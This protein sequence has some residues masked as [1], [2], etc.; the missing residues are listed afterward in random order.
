MATE[1]PR[2]QAYLEPMTYDLLLGWK[3]QRGIT[4]ESEAINQILTEYFGVSSSSAPVA[5]QLPQ[6]AIEKIVRNEVNALF[7]N[8]MEEDAEFWVNRLSERLATVEQSLERFVSCSHRQIDEL[9]AGLGERLAACEDSLEILLS[10]SPSELPSAENDTRSPEQLPKDE[11]PGLNEEESPT[12]ELESNPKESVVEDSAI[13]IESPG[14]PLGNSP[15]LS[16]ADLA[17]LLSPHNQTELAQRLG[18]NKS[19]VSRQK[20]KPD[21]EQWSQGKDPD[22]IGW[23]YDRS[24][25]MF[26]PALASLINESQ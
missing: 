25:Q 9:K 13:S 2:I 5:Q 20:G 6:E 10:D 11:A 24:S 16:K 26:S 12:A 17:A 1:R 15:K 14:K 4:K 8:K 19:Q 18:C 3:K 22:G 21:F 23:L 7:K